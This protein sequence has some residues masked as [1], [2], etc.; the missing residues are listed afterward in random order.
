MLPD[1]AIAS[2]FVVDPAHPAL[3]GHFPDAPIVPAALLIEHIEAALANSGKTLLG[4]QRM[5][6]F[7]PVAPGALVSVRLDQLQ[8]SAGT[9]DLRVGDTLVARGRWLS[10]PA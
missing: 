4:L 8:D 7:H 9:V 1:D 5:K 6:F 3:A 10:Q 2:S